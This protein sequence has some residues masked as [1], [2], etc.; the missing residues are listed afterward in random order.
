MNHK[1]IQ[2]LW[3]EEG[4][5]VVVK[6]RRKRMGVSTVPEIAAEKTNDV[7]S[8]DFQFDSTVTGKPLKIFSIV[9]EHTRECLGGLV[10]YSITGLNLAEPL[11]ILV[12]DRG[13]PK[14][15]RMDHGAELASKTL[16]EWTNETERIFIPPG[17]PWRKRIRRFI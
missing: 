6:R 11:D 4:L 9:E 3:A 14:A 10:D 7:W 16:A 8:V 12:I 13:I 15:L 17:Q 1:K 2:R 5:R